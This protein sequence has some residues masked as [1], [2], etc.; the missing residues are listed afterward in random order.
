[1]CDRLPHLGPTNRVGAA[2]A[3]VTAPTMFIFPS[4]RSARIR[5]LYSRFLCGVDSFFRLTF[6]PADDKN[7]KRRPGLTVLFFRWSAPSATTWNRFLTALLGRCPSFLP[8]RESLWFPRRA[9][10][11]EAIGSPPPPSPPP[12]IPL[13]KSLVH[14]SFF[15]L[16]RPPSSLVLRDLPLDGVS[17]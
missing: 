12:R 10:Q 1:V 15:G 3:H 9:F 4:F 7:Q 11:P 17:G 16:S 8:I 6:P 5:Y 2:P 13:R 14:L